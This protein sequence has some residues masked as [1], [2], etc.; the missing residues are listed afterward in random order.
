MGGKLDHFPP[1]GN[2][3]PVYSSPLLLLAATW[4]SVLAF[5]C[6]VLNAFGPNV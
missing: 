6:E 5:R 1:L 4:E 2:A 3:A